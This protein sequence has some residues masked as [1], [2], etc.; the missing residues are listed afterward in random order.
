MFLKVKAEKNENE[1]GGVEILSAILVGQLGCW[2]TR[3][4][5][6]LRVAGKWVP[7]YM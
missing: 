5:P 4:L 2:G 7:Y 6:W 3:Q 1:N